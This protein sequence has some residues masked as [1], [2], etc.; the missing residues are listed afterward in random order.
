MKSYSLDLDGFELGDNPKIKPNRHNI[1]GHYD[2]EPLEK[3]KESG[4]NLFKEIQDNTSPKKVLLETNDQRST[5]SQVPRSHLRLDE[6]T[7]KKGNKSKFFKEF[8]AQHTA[9][10]N[11]Q[12]K[13]IQEIF[14]S[15]SE[16]IRMCK[17]LV[18]STSPTR[19]KNDTGIQP[20]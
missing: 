8:I 1:D 9:T 16:T 19:R 13:A 10:V 18:Y 12:M 14:G 6:Q 2:I 5:K 4:Y 7:L 11:N 17:E 15:D 20:D 3:L